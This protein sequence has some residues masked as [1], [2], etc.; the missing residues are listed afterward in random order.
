[1]HIKYQFSEYSMLFYWHVVWR[2]LFRS[3]MVSSLYI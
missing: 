3:Y 2:W 1:M